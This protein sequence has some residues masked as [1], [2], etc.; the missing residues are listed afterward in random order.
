MS[1]GQYKT[2]A[3][4]SKSVFLL[5]SLVLFC[6]PS[7][8]VRCQKGIFHLSNHFEVQRKILKKKKL[9]INEYLINISRMIEKKASQIYL[10]QLANFFLFLFQP[11][12]MRSSRY[13]PFSSTFSSTF[14]SFAVLN[15]SF[16]NTNIYILLYVSNCIYCMQLHGKFIYI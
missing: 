3:L 8:M 14:S 12:L 6:F 1:Q 16:L 11:Y 4:K 9:K 5:G 7:F 10:F 15:I 2:N 13:I